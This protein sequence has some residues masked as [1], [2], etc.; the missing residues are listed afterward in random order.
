M[1]NLERAWD[2]V[3]R[4]VFIKKSFSIKRCGEKQEFAAENKQKKNVIEYL[5]S[6]ENVW[7]E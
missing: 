4:N 5:Q 3:F 2:Y 1:G 7:T 6:A